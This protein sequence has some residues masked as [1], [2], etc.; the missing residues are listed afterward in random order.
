M[1]LLKGGLIPSYTLW[2][3]NH[4]GVVVYIIGESWKS[5]RFLNYSRKVFVAIGTGLN[6]FYIWPANKT[7]GEYVIDVRIFWLLDTVSGEKKVTTICCCGKC[8][9]YIEKKE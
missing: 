6:V 5:Q 8:M 1:L 3:F 2:L 7:G 9:S 4:Y